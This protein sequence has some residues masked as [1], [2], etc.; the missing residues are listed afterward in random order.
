M[1]KMSTSAK[2]GV[3]HEIRMWLGIALRAAAGSALAIMWLENHPEI[4][5][6]IN[7]WLVEHNLKKA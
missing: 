7:D 1:K 4:K 6:K 3:S 2:I 5:E